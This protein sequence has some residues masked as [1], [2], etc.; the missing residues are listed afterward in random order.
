MADH[1]RQWCSGIEFP[2]NPAAIPLHR[3]VFTNPSLIKK[4]AMLLSNAVAY[5]NINSGDC[6][7]LTPLLVAA[8]A[9]KAN[10]F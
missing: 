6:M 7:G 5:C 4:N 8:H 1:L 2:L 3:L 10:A 9:N